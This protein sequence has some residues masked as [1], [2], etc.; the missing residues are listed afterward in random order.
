MPPP[1]P[2]ATPN[3]HDAASSRRASGIRASEANPGTAPSTVPATSAPDDTI[4]AT[5]HPLG[6]DATSA[7]ASSRDAIARSASVGDTT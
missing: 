7:R 3:C 1:T 5:S 2:G 6:V 4:A